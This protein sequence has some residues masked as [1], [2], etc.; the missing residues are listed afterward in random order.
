LCGNMIKRCW[1]CGE[2]VVKGDV[3]Y[4]IEYSDG[5]SRTFHE[6]CYQDMMKL[7]GKK[8]LYDIG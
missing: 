1:W 2:H 7:L 4:S 3:V 8:G 5:K 6:T